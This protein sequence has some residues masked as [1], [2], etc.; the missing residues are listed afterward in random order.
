MHKTTWWYPCVNRIESRKKPKKPVGYSEPCSIEKKKK[1]SYL[2]CVEKYSS[3]Y[4][5][6]GLHDLSLISSLLQLS[7]TMSSHP[8]CTVV[9]LQM[10]PNFDPAD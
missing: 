5:I 3:I 4:C 8:F 1:L 10:L 9:V 2:Y 6:F 7:D